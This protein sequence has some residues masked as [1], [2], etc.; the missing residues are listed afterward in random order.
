M[1]QKYRQKLVAT[2]NAMQTECHSCDSLFN[3]HDDTHPETSE[4]EGSEFSAMHTG[5]TTDADTDQ[6]ETEDEG[7]DLE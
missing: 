2:V 7:S 1:F 4:D 6:D 3:Q 5:D